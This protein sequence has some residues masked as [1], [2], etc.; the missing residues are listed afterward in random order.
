MKVLAEAVRA[1]NDIVVPQPTCSYVLK[2]DYLDYVGGPDAE[3][4]AAHT[5]DA[6][7][8][9]MKAAQ[10]RGHEP[11]H[12][13]PRRRARDDHLPHALPP[14]GPEHRPE[15][16]R[17]D[18]ADRGQDHPGAAVLRHRRHVGPA[19]RE[20]R[21]VAGRGPEAGGRDRRGPRAR[22]SPATA[23]SPTAPSP[24]RPGACP[25][26]PIQV[27]ARA[28]GIPEETLVRHARPH[29][30]R[31]TTSPTCAPTSAS[32][33]TSCAT[34]IALK[35]R[36]RVGVGPIVT[37][38]FEN[39]DTVRFQV[40]EM[41]RAEKLISDDG[42]Q[43]E[44]DVYNPLIPEPGVLSATMFVELTSD[45]RPAGVAA[46]ARRA[47]SATPSLELR[48]RP[49]WCAP[50]P[51]PSTPASS[52]TTTS[53]SSVHYVRFAL[54]PDAGGGVRHRAGRAGR[55]PP[56]LRRAH[57]LGPDTV[58]E[59]RGGRPVRRG[60]PALV[61]RIAAGLGRSTQAGQVDRRGPVGR[62]AAVGP[63]CTWRKSR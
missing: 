36:R 28:Y 7:E 9:L 53:P 44:L 23:T 25:M 11:R 37:F 55:R 34:I 15:E 27:V 49:R 16:P 14:A 47:S 59:L 45:G 33:P 12:R 41:A 40:Q 17:P 56:E 30:D 38:V 42:I 19:R 31:S 26:H 39:R 4:V 13:L 48:R 63:T 54:T 8:Y 20:R 58:T 51:R 18:E 22:S 5:Y 6:A 35:R 61:T 60:R 3:L 24:S 29:P 57:E 62:H 21:A 2:K 50:S 32:A 10:G 52:P 1:G 46:Q 43:T